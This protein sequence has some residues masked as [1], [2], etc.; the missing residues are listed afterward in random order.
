MMTD[1]NNKPTNAERR[2]RV[3]VAAPS[4]DIYG[5]QALMAARL[6]ERLRAEPAL[7]VAFQP[8]NPR[9]PRGLAW[10]QRIKYVRTIATTLAYLVMLIARAWRYDI[11]HIFT[12]SYYSYLLSAVPALLVAR[13]YGKKTILNYRSGEAEDHLSNWPSAV[14]TCRWADR[15]VVPSGYLVDLFARFGLRAK[16]IFNTIELDRFR[17]R[18][19]RPLRPLFVSARLLE[20]LYNVACALRAFALVQQRYPEAQLV[21]AADGSER[22]KLEQLAHELN[23]QHT[24][25]LGK[26]DYQ[27]M[28]GLLDAADIYLN[29]NDL[30]NMP[31]SL[32]ECM[33]AGVSVV[34]TNAGGI[35][36]IITD[37][38]TGLLVARND[39][40]AMARAAIR[41]LEDGEM[42]AA[43]SNRAR[44]ESE[45]YQW[46]AV[47]N[48]WLGLY[49]QLADASA[50][51]LN[52][53]R[54]AAQSL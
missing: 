20:P 12:A 4:L 39:H 5:G 51:A 22:G 25:F 45:K 9:L 35:P 11:I 43:I 49:Q 3:L 14:R 2:I 15:I 18:E 38:Q 10:L 54:D 37:E 46:S 42:A 16:A 21:V 17:F 27:G 1:A 41:L 30:D 28:P 31:S 32:I 44:R 7:E 47:R 34:S 19:R 48:E 53:R 8:H 40:E 6:I 13:A 52:R 50:A 23:L 33:A 29:A 24:R 36:Y 26:V